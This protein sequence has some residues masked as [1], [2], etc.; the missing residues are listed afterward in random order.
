VTTLPTAHTSAQ[1]TKTKTD[2]SAIAQR[3]DAEHTLALRS[4]ESAIEHALGAGRLLLE[5]K[6]RLGRGDWLEWLRASVNVSERQAQRYMRAA[7]N[8]TRVSDS[9][10][11]R[12]LLAELATP[13]PPTQ[14]EPASIVPSRPLPVVVENG[15][16]TV[17]SLD[18]EPTILFEESHRHPG[19]FYCHDLRDGTV[20]TRPIRADLA[21]YLL[22][23]IPGAASCEWHRVDGWAADCLA[24]REEPV[25]GP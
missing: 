7:A 24:E 8:A 2:L 9:R 11:L 13:R 22:D 3:I 10:S 5:A 12:G 21:G 6:A 14:P 16:L 4:A 15:W 19:F 17:G 20:N 25:S 18:G 23:G 1:P